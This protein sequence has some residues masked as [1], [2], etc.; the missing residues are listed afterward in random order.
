[1]DKLALFSNEK[2]KNY[3]F[4]NINLLM[5]YSGS[6]KTTLLSD[7]NH[8]F[9]GKTKNYLV[10][11]LPIKAND[12][13]IINISSFEDISGHFKTNSK[14][15][16]KRYLL[17]QKYSDNF[18]TDCHVILDSF[19]RVMEELSSYLV[20]VLPDLDCSLTS[21]DA[22]DIILNSISISTKEEYY[23]YYRKALFSLISE[24]SKEEQKKT[25]VF[26][27]DFDSSLGEEDFLEILEIMKASNAY[28][29]LT[30]SKALPQE[31]LD[32]DLT[33]YALREGNMIP[34]PNIKDLISDSIENQPLYVSF[35]EYML[36][37][38][39]LETSGIIESFIKRMKEDQCSNLMRILT[40]KDPILT[41]AYL[42]GKVCI[43]LRSKEEEKIYKS[44]LE[45][46]GLNDNQVV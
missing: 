18:D 21:D 22:F 46:L 34:F 45:I 8:I 12:F 43:M 42:P 27:D 38:G 2:R 37:K 6:G 4:S 17:N 33:I 32:T 24:I 23:S 39:Y 36:S 40:A 3:Y 44:A 31:I 30:S 26:I 7:L 9:S 35:E 41:E 11:G 16:I 20:R 19:K 25:L 29:F 10:N 5:G 1:M 28:Y 15:L 13:N 14:S